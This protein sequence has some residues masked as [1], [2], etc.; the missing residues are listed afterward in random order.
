MWWFC[1]VQMGKNLPGMQETQVWSLGWEDLLEKKISTREDLLE[2]AA[3][4][5][6]L[7]WRIQWTEEPGRLQSKWSQR[8]G[9]DWATNTSTFLPLGWKSGCDGFVSQLHR[10]PEEDGHFIGPPVPT[11]TLSLPLPL[12]GLVNS[13]RASLQSL[14]S[15]GPPPGLRPRPR[16]ILDANFTGGDSALHL[17]V[18]CQ[19]RESLW[20]PTLSTSCSLPLQ[21]PFLLHLKWEDFH[22]IG[23]VCAKSLQSRPTLC[24]PMA[25]SPPG[26]SV[27]GILQQESWSVLPLPPPR[28]L[29]NPGIGPCLPHCRQILYHWVVWE[30]LIGV[31]VRPKGAR[32]ALW[33]LFSHLFCLTPFNTFVH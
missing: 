26:S 13:G 2:K 11:H 18:T 15:P 12:S 31:G 24:N 7:A 30:A 19:G 25:C 32:S 23:M 22:F 5:R 16:L 27:H 28:D 33:V 29:P 1:M 3:H 6:T 20:A 9:H 17:P 21:A 4:S 14:L 10:T 8:V